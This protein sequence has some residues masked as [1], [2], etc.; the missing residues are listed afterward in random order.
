MKI[1]EPR[2]RALLSQAERN[3]SNGKI[4][5]AETMYRQILDEAPE[6]EEAW[7]GLGDAMLDPDT[8][9]RGL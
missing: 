2:L 1:S 5:A 7:V 6:S 9:A 8:E 4:A 3:L